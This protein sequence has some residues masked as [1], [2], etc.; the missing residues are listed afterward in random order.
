MVRKV[1]KCMLCIFHK[2]FYAL[3]KAMYGGA[4]YVGMNRCT[5]V[6][7]EKILMQC[8]FQKQFKV[9]FKDIDGKAGKERSAD[10]QMY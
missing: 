7:I 3:L 6:R 10:A 8:I 1:N 2:K 9:L 4:M 5:D